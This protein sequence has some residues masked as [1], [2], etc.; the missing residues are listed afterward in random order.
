MARHHIAVA[1]LDT[2]DRA[3]STDGDLRHTVVS[4][5]RRRRARQ[6]IHAKSALI[7]ERKRRGFQRR[8]LR[9]EED[10]RARHAGVR[11]W[12]VEVEDGAGAWGDGAVVLSAI[13][14]VGLGGVDGDNEV[15]ILVFAAKAGRAGGAGGRLSGGL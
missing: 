12:Q 15:R 2:H 4:S 7:V 10:E 5:L 11:R 14:R 8:L 1:R 13:G 9:E 3:D 6:L